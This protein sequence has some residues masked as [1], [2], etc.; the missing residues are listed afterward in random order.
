MIAWI[1]FIT[2][3]IVIFASA[4]VKSSHL[5]GRIL[6][7][8]AVLLG[9][10]IIVSGSLRLVPGDPIDHI[11]GDQA[12][13]ASREVLAK[14]LG[15]IDQDGHPISFVQQYGYFLTSL[16]SGTIKSFVSRRN[17]LDV[18]AERL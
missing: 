9:A 15:L 16:F 6:S 4:K 11:L 17:A 2:A 5:F 8:V 3:L 18:V 12:Q 13:G 1:L 10:S 7:L 14:D